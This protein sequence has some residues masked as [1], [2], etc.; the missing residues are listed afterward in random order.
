MSKPWIHIKRGDRPLT[1]ET[2]AAIHRMAMLA[3]AQFSKDVRLTAG[4]PTSLN[5]QTERSEESGKGRS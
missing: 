5:P 1:P 2:A 4:T 3:Y